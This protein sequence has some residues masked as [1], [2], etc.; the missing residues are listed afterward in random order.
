MRNSVLKIKQLE[1]TVLFFS[2]LLSTSLCSQTISETAQNQSI[3]KYELLNP[4]RLG[5]TRAGQPIH[6][7]G[8]SGLR[9]V[10]KKNGKLIFV[11][12]TDRGPNPHAYYKK[13]IL[14]RPFM[15]PEFNPRLIF[16]EVDPP[17][18]TLKIIKQIPLKSDNGQLLT[19]LPSMRTREHPVNLYGKKLPFDKKGMDLESIDMAADGGYWMGDEYGPSLMYFSSQG[20]LLALFT[21]AAGLPKMITQIKPNFGFEGIALHKDKLFAILQGPLNKKNNNKQSKMIRIIE[22]DTKK[23]RTVGQYLYILEEPSASIGDMAAL[24]SNRFLVIEQNG[25][26]GQSVLKKIFLIDLANATNIQANKQPPS[27]NAENLESIQLQQAG[28]RTVSKKEVLNLAAL[29]IKNK[30]IEGIALV[31]QKHI[32]LITD[33]DFE[34][35]GELNQKTGKAKFKKENTILFLIPLDIAKL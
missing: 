8:F 26:K 16:L 29:G 24:G 20:K 15:L 25:R 10:G 28:V 27:L 5:V 32:A 11:T 6:L 22:F 31:N 19:G 3:A 7:G 4:P 30:K 33:N 14:M 23:R 2:L 1:S 17:T 12:H 34:L 13:G 9:F 35:N 18:K 21:P